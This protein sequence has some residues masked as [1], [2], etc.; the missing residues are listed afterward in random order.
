MGDSQLYQRS[1]VGD[2]STFDGATRPLTLTS[3]ER[4]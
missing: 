1:T 3:C 2:A 4:K